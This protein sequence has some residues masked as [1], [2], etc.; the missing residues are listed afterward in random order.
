MKSQNITDI[1]S[2][3]LC[4]HRQAFNMRKRQHRP[5]IVGKREEFKVHFI[6]AKEDL[7]FKNS[8]DLA[9]HKLNIQNIFK[10]EIA[11][12]EYVLYQS[13]NPNCIIS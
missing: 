1:A 8:I 2:V 9:L 10:L 12:Y 13:M 11:K 6:H 4:T 3:N 5:V 7:L